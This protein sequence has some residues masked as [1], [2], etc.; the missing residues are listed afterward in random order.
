MKRRI[1]DAND[2]SSAN[3]WRTG[4]GEIHRRH[5]PDEAIVE[6]HERDVL[7]MRLI[8]TQ[9]L[10]RVERHDQH[11]VPAAGIVQFVATDL[12]TAN[13]VDRVAKGQHALAEGS[14]VCGAGSL[15]ILQE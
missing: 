8:G 6:A 1:D 13:L 11:Q 4:S 10:D 9:R 3:W 12:E 7:R 14:H 15:S 5:I 2:K